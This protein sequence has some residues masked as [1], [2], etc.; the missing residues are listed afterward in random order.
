MARHD[1][2]AVVSRRELAFRLLA[3]VALGCHAF[4]HGIWIAGFLLR[5]G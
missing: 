3:A 5:P 4:W 1:T 2:S